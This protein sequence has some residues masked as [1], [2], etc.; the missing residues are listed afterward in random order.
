MRGYRGYEQRQI[1]GK[2]MKQK[3]LL[4]LLIMI[5]IVFGYRE[6][7]NNANATESNDDAT[8][9]DSQRLAEEAPRPAQEEMERQRQEAAGQRWV[10]NGDGTVSD[11]ETGLMWAAKDN[12]G[13]ITWDDARR[14]CENYRGGGYSDWRLPTIS[15]LRTLYDESIFQPV[16][17]VASGK[18]SHL[19]IVEEIGLTCFLVWS[20]ETEGPPSARAF[21]F[22]D[23]RDYP[24]Y[25][26]LSDYTRALPVRSSR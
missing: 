15:E 4:F 1:E 2:E 20:S 21:L 26:S 13:I 3:R 11:A 7:P 19:H 9:K 5:L 8:A 17:C 12:G 25:R 10:D 24:L 14:Y 18:I 6:S 23:G 16:T 22:H